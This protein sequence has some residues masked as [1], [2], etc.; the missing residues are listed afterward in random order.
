[1][2][3]AGKELSGSARESG[4][5][6]KY[7]TIGCDKRGA[8]ILRQ[9]DELAVVGRA[10][11]LNSKVQ[12]VMRDDTIFATRHPSFSFVYHSERNL[13]RHHAVAD[14]TKQCVSEFRTPQER[15]DPRRI[16]LKHG[17]CFGGLPALDMKLNQQIRVHDDHG[18]PWVLKRSIRRFVS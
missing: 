11:G 1:M 16:A 10:A 3:R 4:K 2:A 15:S 6:A 8:E 14:E 18:R 5:C 13:K 7:L 9:T 17:F 12:H